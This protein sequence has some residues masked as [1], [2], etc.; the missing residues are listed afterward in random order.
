MPASIEQNI[1]SQFEKVF[2]QNDW[3]TFKSVAT[4]ETQTL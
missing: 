4:A 2:E 1:K 3:R